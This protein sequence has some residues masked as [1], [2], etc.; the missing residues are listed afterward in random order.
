MDSKD[1]LILQALRENSSASKRN[2]AK[3]TGI[4][5]TTVFHRSQRMEKEGI[6][7][8]Y[9]VDID[10][11]KLG[12]GICAFIFAS[13]KQNPAEVESV[14]QQDIART[15]LKK[16]SRVESVSIVTGEIDLIIKARFKSIQQ[17]NSFITKG[18]RNIKGIDRTITSIA[19]EEILEA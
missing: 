4:P 5:L 10:F 15:I 16:F 13:I 3:K 19:L 11:D 14:S 17:L 8:K 9:T 1:E 7:K 12:Y 2:I 18:L 6:I